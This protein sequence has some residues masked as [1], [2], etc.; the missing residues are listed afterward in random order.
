MVYPGA[1]I[2]VSTGSAWATSLTAP[3]GAVVGTTDTQTLTNKRVTPRANI[4]ASTTSP[5]AW[6]SDSYDIQGFTAL[7]NALTINADAGTP[8]DGQ[9]TIFRLKDNATARALTW[10]TGTSKS[11]LA[12]GIT[13]PTT[14]VLSK[15]V[16]VGCIYNS[17]SDRWE[18]V[19]TA[20]EA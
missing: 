5:W 17:N 18:A 20:Q 12:V 16:Y 14:T 19:A 8:T 9:K 2:A 1:G 10:T 15:V 11:F 4:T 13:L 7:A 3:S 6:N